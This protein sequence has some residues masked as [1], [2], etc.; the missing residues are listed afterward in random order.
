MNKP[1]PLSK[2]LTLRS[3]YFKYFLI[4]V[5]LASLWLTIG[6]QQFTTLSNLYQE[7]NKLQTNISSLKIYLESSG[8][9]EKKFSLL[10]KENRRLQSSIPP[11]GNMAA[12]LNRLELF[13]ANHNITVNKII[14]DDSINNNS[15]STVKLQLTVS[16]LQDD[17]CFFLEDFAHLDQLMLIE[18]IS[19]YSEINDELA[20][21]SIT[22][23]LVLQSFMP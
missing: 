17:I 5:V 2:Y 4:L 21:L 15:Y 20:T 16:G 1:S 7:K 8:N 10:T 18:N 22:T 19:W 3:N 9:L 6:H 12:A 11:F 14:L 23:N 13:L